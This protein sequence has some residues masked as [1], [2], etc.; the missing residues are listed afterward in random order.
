MQKK[1]NSPR[2]KEQILGAVD[3]RRR[4]ASMIRRIVNTLLLVS[5]YLL[6]QLVGRNGEGVAGALP[7][8]L[9]VA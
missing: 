5:S 2:Y 1:P 9:D 8:V 3:S 7:Q 4:I 6:Q